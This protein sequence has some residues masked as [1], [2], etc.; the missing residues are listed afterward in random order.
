MRFNII[1]MLAMIFTVQ[2]VTAQTIDD[3]VRYSFLE[4][5]GTARTV[6]V[7]GAIG[8]LGAD[9]STL[10]TNPAGLA[11]FRRSEFT[12]TPTLDRST[13]EATLRGERNPLIDQEKSN[14]NFNNLGLVFSSQ[15]LNSD[16]T[17]SAFGFGMNRMAS[18]H[19]SVYFEGV[20]DGS[21]TDRWLELAQGLE[22]NELDDFEAGLAYDGAAIYRPY[23]ALEP[24]FYV[25]DF[26]L[27]APVNKSQ[28]IRRK[29]A[30]NEMLFSF[31]G[32]Y[33]ERLLI[34]ATL[35]VPFLSFEEIKT[36]QE[37]DT[38][39][40]IPTFQD[41]TYTERL[42]TTGTGINLKLGLIYR[43]NQMVRFGFAFH[44]PTRFGLHD[45]F[46]SDLDYNYVENGA[47]YSG[48]ASSPE[49]SFEYRLR[50]PW[51]FIGS[52]GLIFGKR[53]FVSAEVE[54]LDYTNARFN[55]HKTTNSADIKYQREL[56]GD[57]DK[58]LQSALNVRL[59]GEFAYE[60][61]RLRA[62]FALTSAPFSNGGDPTA[63]FSLGAGL[64]GENVFLDLAFRRV[65]NDT[66]YTPYTTTDAA[67]PFVSLKETKSRIMAT[68]G[69]KF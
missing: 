34:G 29:G 5:G 4:P 9:F 39:D 58:Y 28:L 62:G 49:G 65:V 30:I 69:F 7:G 20:S 16:W 19:Q 21:I 45:S 37:S 18:F 68:V 67:Q 53:G 43:V 38:A 64:R 14:F 23:P 22:L 66:D 2:I 12:F 51:R 42:R 40:E 48:E 24:T 3:A 8:A 32:N 10:S 47:S 54:W 17:V 1:F 15:P 27:D 63:A 41:L 6:G 56:N 44:T 61:F 13:T 52:G 33:K 50:T 57:I 59:G 31:A 26:P 35:G 46:S 11:N 55:F 36:Y 60:M 25:S